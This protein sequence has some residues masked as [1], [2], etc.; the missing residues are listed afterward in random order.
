MLKI[1]N[2]NELKLVAGGE[3]CPA[4]Y[5]GQPFTKTEFWRSAPYDKFGSFI[6]CFYG[7]E[8]KLGVTFDHAKITNYTDW[9]YASDTQLYTIYKC[10]R[11]SSDC[12]FTL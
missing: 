2:S 11:S 6:K 1:S 5:S 3:I 9:H 10:I 12:E 7:K 8:R 4:E